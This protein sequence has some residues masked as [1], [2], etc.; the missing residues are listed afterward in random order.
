[1]FNAMETRMNTGKLDDSSPNKFDK[2][3]W[4]NNL[5]IQFSDIPA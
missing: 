3:Y 5:E 4:Q 1:M 2:S